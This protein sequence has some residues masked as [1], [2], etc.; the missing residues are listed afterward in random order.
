MG[1]LNEPPSAASAWAS[2][3][4]VATPVVTATVVDVVVGGALVDVEEV[5]G[6]VVEVVEALVLPDPQPARTTPNT[7][8][9]AD[10]IRRFMP[11][12]L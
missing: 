4:Q 1:P 7:T 2:V 8:P 3:G 10:T 12:M 6:V 5:V 9:T 11:V